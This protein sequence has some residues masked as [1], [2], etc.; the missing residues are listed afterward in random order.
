MK[1]YDITQELFC[2]RIYPGDTAPSYDRVQKI[3]EGDICNL[4]HLTMCVHNATHL[5]APYHFYEDGKTIDQLELSRCVGSCTVIKLSDYTEQ[6]L[7]EVL[8][9]CKKRLLIKGNIDI[10]LNMAKIFNKHQIL[11]IGVEGQSVGSVDS[12]APVHYELL[13]NEVALLEG[14]DLSEVETGDY[15]LSAAPLKLGGCDGAPCRAILLHF[16]ETDTC[17]Y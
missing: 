4:T 8:K 16:I 2:G 1:I 10:T 6:E 11:L 14:I 12:P 15:F 5:D 9:T 13:K 3:A 7:E 17:I